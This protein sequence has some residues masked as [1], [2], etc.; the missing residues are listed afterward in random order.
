M[1]TPS[2]LLLDDADARQ[3]RHTPGHRRI[4]GGDLGLQF[5][6]VALA[7]VDNIAK[8]CCSSVFT[9][10]ETHIRPGRLRSITHTKYEGKQGV[11]LL[12]LH[13]V[14]V[15]AGSAGIGRYRRNAGSQGS[16]REAYWFVQSG[17]AHPLAASPHELRS[18]R[19]AFLSHRRRQSPSL[20]TTHQELQTIFVDE[21]QEKTPRKRAIPFIRR[22]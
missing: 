7:F 6:R 13:Y 14:N 18:R 15:Y 19:S 20:H 1:S 21:M 2:V 22:L 10:T 8:H 3:S 4:P 9:V 17:H 5:D 11:L 12:G 16:C